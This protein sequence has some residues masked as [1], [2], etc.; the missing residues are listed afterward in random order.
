MITLYSMCC[1]LATRKLFVG[2]KYEYIAETWWDNLDVGFLAR[3]DFSRPP[4]YVKINRGQRVRSWS[5]TFRFRKRGANSKIEPKMNQSSDL[6]WTSI[7]RGPPY[8]GLDWGEPRYT[9]IFLGSSAQKCHTVADTKWWEVN[10]YK[11]LHLISAVPECQHRF[12]PHPLRGPRR[13]Q[14]GDAEGDQGRLSRNV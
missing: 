9:F 11:P 6:K 1:Y 12:R 2:N 4:P 14:A 5:H 13:P 10:N 3:F 8:S 7:T